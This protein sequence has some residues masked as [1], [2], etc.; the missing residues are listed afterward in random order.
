[1]GVN[2]ALTHYVECAQIATTGPQ[3]VE[4]APPEVTPSALDV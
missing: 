1:M 3:L 4:V 2:H